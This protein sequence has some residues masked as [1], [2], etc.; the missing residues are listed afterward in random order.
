M[1]TVVLDPLPPDIERLI[2]RRK[3]LGTDLYDEVWEGTYHMAPAP[4]SHHGYLDGELFRVLRPR[5]ERA[6]LVG[7]GPFNLGTPDDF[8]VP[9]QGYHRGLPHTVFVPTAVVVVEIVSQ[10]D[11]TY[12]KLPFYGALSVSEVVIVEPAGRF[13]RVMVLRGAHY[14]E[15]EGSA[16]LGITATDLQAELRWP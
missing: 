12:D 4:H 8:R 14:V 13:V 5:A 2:E 16:A 10:G 7:T 6:G 15:A 1:K 11:E 9:D 3:R